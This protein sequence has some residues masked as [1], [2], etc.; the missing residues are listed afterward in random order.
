LAANRQIETLTG[1]I[2]W[3]A[4]DRVAFA[5]PAA[6]RLFREALGQISNVGQSNVGTFPVRGK[7]A[8]SMIANLIPIRLTARDL[9]AR[10]EA[11]LILTPVGHANAAP[12]EVLQSLF[13]L[14][15]AE[16]RLARSLTEGEPL[17]TIAMK[18]GVTRN[19]LT[20]HLKR[21]FAKTGC[22]RQAE[23]VGL[24]GGLRAIKSANDQERLQSSAIRPK[25]TY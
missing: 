2:L 21:V 23:L 8:T 3:K 1:A 13:D 20:T 11:A 15:P 6:D 18:S 25:S 12:V 22:R 10:S 7:S 17:E 9:F 5:D 4:R 14:T 19:T 24:L 16:A